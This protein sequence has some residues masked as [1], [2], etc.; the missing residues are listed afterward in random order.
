MMRLV[1]SAALLVLSLLSFHGGLA[2]YDQVAVAAGQIAIA[3]DH[4]TLLKLPPALR[5]RGR[6]ILAEPD[7]DTRADLVEALA[8]DDALGALDFLLTVLDTDPSA[9]VRENI[10]DELEEVDDPRVDPALERRVLVDSDLDIALAS[11]ELLRGRATLPLMRL[12]EGRL[13]AERKGGSAD[14]ITRLA[15]EQERWTTVVRGGL[16]PTF[17]QTPPALFSVKPSGQPIRVLAFGDFGDGNEPQKRVAAAMLRYHQQHRFDFGITLGDNFYPTGMA[18]PTDPRWPT[19]WSAL[20]DPLQIPFYATLGNH[21]WNQPNSP[22]AE[23]LFS[24]HSPSWRMPAAYYT[25]EAGPV[26]FFALDTDIISEAQLLWLRTA[27]DQ[28]RATWKVVYG[29]HPIYSAGQHEDNEEK[30]GQLLPVLRGRADLYLAGHD[31]DMQ[32]LKPE[33]GLHFFVAGTGGKLRTIEPGPRSL[34]A[35]SAHGFAVLEADAQALTVT[36]VKEDLS[37]PYSYSL[38]RAQP[39]SPR[40]AP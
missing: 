15:A 20:Y 9:D 17:F 21:D 40:P 30:I 25:F 35:A 3:Q 19:W 10:V 28:S 1:K 32:H 8:D 39:G 2:R 38:N 36:F 23:I 12:L 34:F 7:E 26:Q 31:H 29:H 33:G 24:H 5:D 18:S 14:A 37:S 11:L 13:E 22:A 27:L 6:L 4:P 16:L